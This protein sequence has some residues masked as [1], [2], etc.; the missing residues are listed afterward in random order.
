M[1]AIQVKTI[2]QGVVAAYNEVVGPDQEPGLCCTFETT[3]AAGEL[4]WI[5]VM[6]GTVNMA[7]PFDDDPVARMRSTGAF[8]HLKPE[9]IEWN[10]G[11]FATWDMAGISPRDI[12][13]LVDRLFARVLSCD[14]T[15]YEPRVTME[16]FDA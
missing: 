16:D 14:D 13:W 7:Y 2:E 6:A 15:A 12:A 3:S 10:A 5:Q 9:L 1:G 4:V 11:S 8:G